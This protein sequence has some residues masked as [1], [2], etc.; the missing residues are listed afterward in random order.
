[1]GTRASD[2]AGLA[3]VIW[4]GG[5]KTNPCELVFSPIKQSSLSE[6]LRM[7]KRRY[8]KCSNPGVGCPSVKGPTITSH[9]SL[10]FQT[11]PTVPLTEMDAR[12]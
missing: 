7:W 6:E 2:Q 8:R 10:L 1:M 9:H 3:R 4:M 11:K 12:A 5:K